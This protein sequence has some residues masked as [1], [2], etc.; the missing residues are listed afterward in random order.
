MQVESFDQYT[1]ALRQLPN[2]SRKPAVTSKLEIRDDLDFGAIIKQTPVVDKDRVER[3]IATL[4]GL[5]EDVGL[6]QRDI[7]ETAE[8][9]FYDFYGG[10]I[11]QQEEVADKI[12]REV[13]AL[14]TRM[15]R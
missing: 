9:N 6:S 7:R 15:P 14:Q 10:D 5:Y 4:S 2:T 13:K 1:R 8:M 12:D 11:F 3:S